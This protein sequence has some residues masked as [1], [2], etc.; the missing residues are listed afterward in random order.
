MRGLILKSKENYDYYRKSSDE[1]NAL[2]FGDAA[3]N[4]GIGGLDRE[5]AACGMSPTCDKNKWFG[6]VE[7]FCLK[8]TGPLYGTRSACDINRE[9]PY[10]V[11][12]VR[13]NKYRLYFNNQPK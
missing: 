1:Y 11:F 4:G 12:L 7:R 5:R 3:Y 6:N 9:H 13:A 10:N 2:V 8:S